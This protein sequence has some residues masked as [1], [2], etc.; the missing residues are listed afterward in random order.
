MIY[1]KKENKMK[2]KKNENSKSELLD[3]VTSELKISPIE[4][5]K[6]RAI[7]REGEVI[8]RSKF[9]RGK[10]VKTE[11]NLT[12]SKKKS[13]KKKHKFTLPQLRSKK[14]TKMSA[15]NL[16]MFSSKSKIE[17][18]NLGKKK[19][20]RKKKFRNKSMAMS[21]QNFNTKKRKMDDSVLTTDNFYGRE[22]NTSKMSSS[23]RFNFFSNI[24]KD[25][26]KIIQFMNQSQIL[27]KVSDDRVSK[28]LAKSK[29]WEERLKSY[30][31]SAPMKQRLLQSKT[32]K[33]LAN[34]KNQLEDHT[35]KEM[36][37]L[38]RK[39][40]DLIA[41][42]NK[43]S[44]RIRVKKRELSKLQNTLDNMKEPS[45]DEYN[46]FLK[47]KEELF[48][49]AKNIKENLQQKKTFRSRMER[50][51]EICD[52]NKV[53]N[54]E[55]IRQLT[56]YQTN[57]NKAIKDREAN[58]NS[59][60]LRHEKV[61][62]KIY[63]LID[64]YNKRKVNHGSLLQDI[65]D[66][67]LRKKF[68]DEHISSTDM[69]I[70]ESVKLK[71]K[72]INQKMNDYLQRQEKAKEF[73]ANEKFNKNMNT[74]LDNQRE[75]LKDME[76]LFKDGEAGETWERKPEMR[77]AVLEIERRKDLE[78]YLI[79]KNLELKKMRKKR[80]LVESNLK[81]LK[82]ANSLNKDQVNN[83][84]FFR[85]KIDMIKQSIEKEKV[86]YKKCQEFL[87]TTY[88]I[89]DDTRLILCSIAN[90]LDIF[91]IG[92]NL[93]ILYKKDKI[94]E[95]TMNLDDVMAELKQNLTEEEFSMF[96]EKKKQSMIRDA[97]KVKNVTIVP[98]PIETHRSEDFSK[99]VMK[100]KGETSL[101]Q[102]S[103]DEEM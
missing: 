30:L 91:E 95:M 65:G 20:F 48:Q 74:E 76:I 73:K 63:K 99:P 18:R 102:G 3:S 79:E 67:L 56:F 1:K 72:D 6:V 24:K 4:S 69:I 47:S 51:K 101:S 81:T 27:E 93:E 58:I 68:L 13:K 2:K 66:V 87:D 94:L 85:R 40:Q 16:S 34:L 38:H 70:K 42:L 78:R 103:R 97:L 71:K 61:N 96:R 39:N 53:Q 98:N 88:K 77:K 100:D 92:K 23:E 75:M 44:D 90:I 15:S 49:K 46:R 80:T 10:K 89:D 50:I 43:V 52:L 17:K 35:K 26:S 33:S 7:T 60:D 83:A 29:F 32:T 55:W 9:D 11:A 57:L 84:D 22:Q 37:I 59:I 12:S 14:T 31:V 45:N 62:E 28:I 41:E 5:K 25:K 64:D 19:N 82:N 21:S 8:K 36:K 86:T 54:E